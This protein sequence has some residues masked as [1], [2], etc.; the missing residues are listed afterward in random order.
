MEKR[1]KM[2]IRQMALNAATLDTLEHDFAEGATTFISVVVGLDPVTLNKHEN[3]LRIR[4]EFKRV[5]ERLKNADLD[6]DLATHLQAQLRALEPRKEDEIDTSAHGIAYFAGPDEGAVVTTHR[7]IET[8]S[9]ISGRPFLLPLRAA[10]QHSDDFFLVSVAKDKVRAW[11]GDH[12]SIEEK[13]SM[14]ITDTEFARAADYADP[15]DEP[16][17]SHAHKSEAGARDEAI[18]HGHSSRDEDYEEKRITRFYRAADERL[19][20]LM[21]GEDNAPAILAGDERQRAYFKDVAKDADRYEHETAPL[22]NKSPNEL[23]AQAVEMVRQAQ[24]RHEDLLE[25]WDHRVSQ[26]RYEMDLSEIAHKAAHGM[27]ETLLVHRDARAWGNYDSNSGEVE[28][29]AEK[30]DDPSA[31]AVEL[32]DAIAARVAEL[33]GTIHIFDKEVMPVDSAMCAFLRGTY[34]SADEKVSA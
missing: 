31:E 9:T 28:I 4:N 2:D 13:L 20:E 30:G 29:L 8:T 32:R 11:S 5:R 25:T 16:L 24:A 17:Q 7:E 3:V 23:R 6:E 14:E 15:E 33:G 1:R 19:R 27:I 26:G 18:F 21:S 22:G 10:L 12:D 34:E